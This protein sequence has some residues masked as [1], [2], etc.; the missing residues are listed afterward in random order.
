MT[1]NE[2]KSYQSLA[3]KAFDDFLKKPTPLNHAIVNDAVKLYKAALIVTEGLNSQGDKTAEYIES[4]F[5][6]DDE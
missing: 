2:L 3:N 6:E 5:G 1:D 4:L